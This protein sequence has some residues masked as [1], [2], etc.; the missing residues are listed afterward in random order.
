[1]DVC[2]MENSI[3][4]L[5]FSIMELKNLEFE[6]QKYVNEHMEEIAKDHIIPEIKN[7]ASAMNIPQG[8][9]DGLEIIKSSKNS[10][11]IINTWG[12]A[13]KPLAKWFNYGTKDH[14]P[15]TANSLHWKD[16]KTGK[17][18]FAKFVHGIPKTLAMEKGIELGK[19][20]FLDAILEKAKEHVKEEFDLIS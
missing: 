16:K 7:M 15:V 4:Q 1:M 12:S 9:S 20:R 13:E 14:G 11:K 19:K 2:I 17:D 6:V 3:T 10:I 18:I 8:F 5:D